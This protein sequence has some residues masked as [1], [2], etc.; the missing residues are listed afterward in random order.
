M[1]DGSIDFDKKIISVLEVHLKSISIT[2]SHFDCNSIIST[3]DIHLKNEIL[4]DHANLWFS[5]DKNQQ[6]LITFLLCASDKF[7][8]HASDCISNKGFGEPMEMVKGSDSSVKQPNTANLDDPINQKEGEEPQLSASS[9]V[10]AETIAS[11]AVQF[12]TP[13]SQQQQLPLTD[14]SN[15]SNSKITTVSSRVSL[16][17]GR[18]F[19]GK[20]RVRFGTNVDIGHFKDEI[21]TFKSLIPSWM[22]CGE[23]SD[24]CSVASMP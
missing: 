19:Q 1:P 13:S 20:P 17:S 22:M 15:A 23:Q 21:Q 16:C 14:S 24:V 6:N 3:E 5:D 12:S 11:N 2:F 8:V 18:L 7:F 9:C 4:T 10:D